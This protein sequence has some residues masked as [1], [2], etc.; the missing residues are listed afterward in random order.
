MG[1]EP[2]LGTF[3]V[4]KWRVVAGP[5]G[6][7]I[8]ESLEY[9]HCGAACGACYKRAARAAKAKADTAATAGGKEAAATAGAAGGAA[10]GAAAAAAAGEGASAVVVGTTALALQGAVGRGPADAAEVAAAIAPELRRAVAQAVAGATAP[11]RR[12]AAG[13]VVS[14]VKDELKKEDLYDFTQHVA[15]AME[16]VVRVL[17]MR[18]GLVEYTGRQSALEVVQLEVR[19]GCCYQ[20]CACTSHI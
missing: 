1:R 6:K 19:V 10:A 8:A 11:P 14:S 18:K 12:F 5:D 2:H 9:E 15:A 7:P 20:H 16:Y 17:K 3:S 13:V 4:S